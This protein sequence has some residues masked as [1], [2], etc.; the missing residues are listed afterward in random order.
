VYNLCTHRR[1]LKDDQIKAIAKTGGV[2][3]LNFYSGFLDS[4]YERKAN[5]F[6]AAH[7]AEI[8]EL[9]I[10]KVQADYAFM[11]VAERYKNETADLRATLAKLIEH[12]DYIVKLVGINHVGIGSDFDGIEAPP[13]Q[14]DGVQSFPMLTKALLKHGY[15]KQDVLK[16]LGENF[17]R[18]FKAVSN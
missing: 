16:I 5:A 15:S 9:I 11:F 14:L 17:M 2:I 8:D 4:T 12:L 13:Q 3:F 18:V 10:Q 1:N 7:K 6:K